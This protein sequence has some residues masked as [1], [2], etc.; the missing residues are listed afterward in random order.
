MDPFMFRNYNPPFAMDE[1]SMLRSPPPCA[2]H[3]IHI[4]A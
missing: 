2:V 1:E 4:T 3:P